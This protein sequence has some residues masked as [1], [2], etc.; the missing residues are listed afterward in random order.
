MDDQNDRPGSAQG[1]ALTLFRL[2]RDHHDT[3]MNSGASHRID[4]PEKPSPVIARPSASVRAIADSAVEAAES[5]GDRVLAS[6]ATPSF[7]FDRSHV[8]AANDSPPE[9]EISSDKS[10]DQDAWLRLHATDLIGHLQTW[11]A[12]LD[13]RESQINF[14]SSLQDHRERQFRLLQQDAS[15]E[16]A[17]QQRAIDRLRSEIQAQAR[18]LA[19]EG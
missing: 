9:D 15:A 5:S 7:R 16:M 2:T 4:S 3:A 14:R 6:Q 1:D 10:P 11:A 12:D 18:R 19:F 13:A 17:E 8:S